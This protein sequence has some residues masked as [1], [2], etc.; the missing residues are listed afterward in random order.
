MS[1]FYQTFYGVESNCVVHL[2]PRCNP[3]FFR[4]DRE[5][6]IFFRTTLHN[7]SSDTY[8]EYDHIRPNEKCMALLLA[9]ERLLKIKQ[10]MEE[11]QNQP[12][13]FNNLLRFIDKRGK[14][15]IEIKDALM[16]KQYRQEDIQELMS[17]LLEDVRNISE[18]PKAITPDEPIE[19]PDNSL[20][21]G[22]EHL[23]TISS[24]ENLVPIPNTYSNDDDFED[25]EYV[26]LKEVNDEK[27]FDL[28]DI[29]QIQDVILREK[30]LNDTRYYNIE[31]LKLTLLT[32]RSCA[33][34]SFSISY[35]RRG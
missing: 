17:K 11:E 14:S 32:F 20:S 23:D 29:F 4:L 12:E 26:S 25:V 22:D 6:A 7:S 19:E 34:V 28:E 9:E 27:E 13:V 3:D 30:L 21:M 8:L 10:A 2:C 18:E 33:R 24:V 31:S 1:S 15:F 16:D 35:P 5:R